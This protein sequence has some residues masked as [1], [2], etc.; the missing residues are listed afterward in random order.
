MRNRVENLTE[1]IASI[2]EGMNPTEENDFV[3]P[4]TPYIAASFSQIQETEQEQ[5][6]LQTQERG[7]GLRRARG[8][9]R[10]QRRGQGQ[11]RYRG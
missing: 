5:Q 3:I 8:R 10:P 2:R 9:G 7:Q 1:K 6:N 11:R 4:T